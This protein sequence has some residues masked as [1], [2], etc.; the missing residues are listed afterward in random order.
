MTAQANTTL[1]RA[2]A[3]CLRTVLEEPIDPGRIDPDAFLIDSDGIRLGSCELDSLTFVEMLVALEREV[4][5]EI[6][7]LATAAQLQSLRK[8]S[9]FVAAGAEPDRLRAFEDKWALSCP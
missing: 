5:V 4:E 2:V 8:I 1:E 9:A 7:G 3:N 6:L